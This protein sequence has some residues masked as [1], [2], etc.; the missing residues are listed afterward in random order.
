MIYRKRVRFAGSLKAQC[1]VDVRVDD[2]QET[3][4]VITS[5]YV[6]LSS[7]T[8]SCQTQP[9]HSQALPSCPV[10]THSKHIAFVPSRIIPVCV[11]T[12]AYKFAEAAR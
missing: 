10:D 5:I 11:C 8:S 7:S 2:D 3:A 9:P 1:D 4:K 6:Y 12:A